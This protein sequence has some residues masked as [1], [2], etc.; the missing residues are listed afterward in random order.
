MPALL[1]YKLSSASLEQENS[2]EFVLSALLTIS[3][4]LFV[5]IL[6]NK[7]YKVAGSSFSSMVQGG[8]RF[9]TYVFLALA[10]SIYG[11]E[12]LVLAAIILTFII[13]FINVICIS[14]F[15]LYVNEN[16][17]SLM[18]LLKSILT[19]PLIIACLIG[20]S[21]NFISLE[22]PLVINKILEILSSAALPLGL[23]SVGFGLIIRDMN[24]LKF[25]ITITTIVKLIITPLIMYFICQIFSLNS[26]MTAILII[27]AVLPTA[28][29][30]FVLARQLGG[31]ITLMSS[32]ITVQTLLSAFF[33][34]YVLKYIV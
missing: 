26:Q 18:Y 28:P 29:S 24:S 32:V 12:G 8:V 20:G 19:N 15:A 23:L 4:V 27:F 13:P 10:D 30:S 25:E 22:L 16:K 11:D 3:L 7:F 14:I 6:I 9:N 1:I 31:D 17:L 33:I 2:F 21:I 5:L 34:I